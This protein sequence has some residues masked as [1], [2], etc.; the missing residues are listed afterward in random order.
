MTSIPAYFGDEF[1]PSADWDDEWGDRVTKLVF[2]GV[3]MDRERIIRTLDEA[4]LT[5]AE[6]VSNWRSLN[7]PLTRFAAAR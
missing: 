4:L 1:A 5:P 7:D 2:I 3:G 6:M